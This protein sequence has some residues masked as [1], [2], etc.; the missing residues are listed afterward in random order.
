MIEIN[1]FNLITILVGMMTPIIIFVIF[2]AIIRGIAKTRR[3]IED[4]IGIIIG[5]KYIRHFECP[6][7]RTR[8]DIH[9]RKPCPKCECE[10]F[11]AIN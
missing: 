6:R 3:N 10:L 7:C 2:A 9:K 4:F 1:V 5:S 11:K 8:I